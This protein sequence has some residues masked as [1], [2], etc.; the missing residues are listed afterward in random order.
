MGQPRFNGKAILREKIV[1]YMEMEDFPLEHL[2]AILTIVT[3]FNMSERAER[4]IF[5]F[6]EFLRTKMNILSTTED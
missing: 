2:L 5:D 3:R 6:A 4:E 1:K